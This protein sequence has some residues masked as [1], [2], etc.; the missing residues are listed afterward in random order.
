M[1][2]TAGDWRFSGG[3]TARADYGEESAAAFSLRCD[4]PQRRILLVRTG[5]AAGSRITVRTTFAARVLE[6]GEGGAS[7]LSAAD[8]FLDGL[9][10]SRGRIAIEAAGLPALILP[11]W[12]EPARVV[13]ECRD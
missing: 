1:A 3:P 2:L 9:V 10:S 4:A 13:E 7:M 12:P 5:A 6:V 11:T 8:A